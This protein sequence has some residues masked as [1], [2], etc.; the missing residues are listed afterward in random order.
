MIT[1]HNFSRGVR[2][3]RVVWQCEEMGLAYRAVGYEFP[4]PDAYRAK[5]P[6]GSVP[7]LDDEG[8]VGIGESVA[9]MLYLAQRYGPT[10]LLP[11]APAAMARA[12]QL[13]VA[14]E[15]SLGGL[16]N[17]LMGAKFAA[18]QGEKANW[19]NDFCEARVAGM[20]DYVESLLDGDY[21]VG[22]ALTLADIAIST[23]LGMWEGALGKAI[24]P[25]LAAHRERMQQR[26]AYQRAA[27]AFSAP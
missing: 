21:F 12:L 10:P 23:S 6:P 22:E 25:R 3:L 19:T 9:Q 17:P 13:T 26:P 24:P 18:P 15:A 4:V 20:L 7:F 5:Y 14:S 1:V 2:G 8:G 27:V 16:M 11:A